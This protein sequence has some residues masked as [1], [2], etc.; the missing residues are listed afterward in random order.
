MFGEAP[1]P[2]NF[3]SNLKQ[4][5]SVNLNCAKME[6]AEDEQFFK[7]EEEAKSED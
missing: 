2:Q 3:F 7:E 6:K 5:N 1:K 4:H